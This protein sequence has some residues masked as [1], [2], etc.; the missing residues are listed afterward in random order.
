M[1]GALYINKANLA[2]AT[3]DHTFFF[4]FL[5]CHFTLILYAIPNA[6]FCYITDP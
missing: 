4:L 3:P 2:V 1:L 5:C 6:L